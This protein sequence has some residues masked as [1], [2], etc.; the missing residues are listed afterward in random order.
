MSDIKGDIYFTANATDIDTIHSALKDGLDFYGNEGGAISS[1]NVDITFEEMG[2]GLFRAIFYTD[3]DNADWDGHGAYDI[4]ELENYQSMLY[5]FINA[6][7][8]HGKV[9]FL[10]ITRDNGMDM[11][12]GPEKTLYRLNPEDKTEIMES[13]AIIIYGDPAPVSKS[14]IA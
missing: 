8:A 7:N 1:A 9:T 14:N 5:G 10:D 11:V 12:D 4:E 13:E 6:I 2:E 3:Y